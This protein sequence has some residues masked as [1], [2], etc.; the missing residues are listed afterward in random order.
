MFVHVQLGE[1]HVRCSALSQLQNMIKVNKK[2]VNQSKSK[3]IMEISKVA[4]KI[5]L[6]FNSCTDASIDLEI[7][8]NYKN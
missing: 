6:M 8:K 7:Y 5:E 3:I 2:I 1:C 4:H